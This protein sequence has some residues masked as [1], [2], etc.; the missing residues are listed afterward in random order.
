M[1]HKFSASIIIVSFWLCCGG[2]TSHSDMNLAATEEGTENPLPTMEL[3]ADSLVFYWLPINSGRMAVTGKDENTGLCVS[4]IWDFSNN[5]QKP[6]EH[7]DDFF[8]TFPYV[9]IG[10]NNGPCHTGNWDY[11]GNVEFIS[12]DGCIDNEDFNSTSGEAGHR[13]FVDVSINVE[14]ELFSGT[15]K[16]RSL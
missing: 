1:T 16:A 6:T 4:L 3:S 2:Q 8:D 7:C 11:R 5:G 14:S 10:S 15:I 9:I 13:D 12:G